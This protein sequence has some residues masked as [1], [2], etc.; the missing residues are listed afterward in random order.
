MVPRPE[1]QA[2]DVNNTI[3]ELTR[4]FIETQLSR[5]I[6]YDGNIDNILGYVHHHELLKETG[7]DPLNPISDTGH[8]RDHAC[9]DGTKPLHKK[10]KDDR[11]GCG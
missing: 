7:I 1:I 10:A 5:I 4:M 3:E 8:S 11:L 9:H 2:I 6:V